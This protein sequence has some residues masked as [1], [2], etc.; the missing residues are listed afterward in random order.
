MRIEIEDLSFSYAGRKDK[1]RKYA[2]KNLS[3][4]IEEGDF[5]GIIGQTGSGKSTFVQ[6]LNGLIKNEEK[7]G[8]IVVGGVDL[9]DKN[10]DLKAL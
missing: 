9:K 2:L 1:N 8:K 6:H 5:F 4:T 10:T 7:N 3:L